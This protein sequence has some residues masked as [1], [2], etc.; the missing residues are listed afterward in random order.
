MPEWVQWAEFIMICIIF[1][2]M[3]FFYSRGGRRVP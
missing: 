2:A 3:F 1:L